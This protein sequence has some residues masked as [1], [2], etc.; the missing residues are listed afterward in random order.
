MSSEPRMT[1]AAYCREGLQVVFRN[2][3]LMHTRVA[4]RAEYPTTWRDELHK[5]YGPSWSQIEESS[6]RAQAS[7]ARDTT[8]IDDFDLL[9]VEHFDVLLSSHFEL[10]FSDTRTWA[11]L[12]RKAALT[13]TQRWLKVITDARNV[14]AHATTDDLSPHNVLE[15]LWAAR[16]VLRSMHESGPSTELDRLIELVFGQ[17]RRSSRYNRML[18]RPRQ[19]KRR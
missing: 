3:V 7:G 14:I 11:P 2:A 6:Q 16:H 5:A 8:P 19:A 1:L 13:A 4:F 9:G 15:P 12:A 10:L 17:P 18:A